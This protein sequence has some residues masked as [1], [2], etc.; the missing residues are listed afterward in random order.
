[1]P[2]EEA[3]DV[4]EESESDVVSDGAAT[5]DG[6]VPAE[7]E[8]K[9]YWIGQFTGSYQTPSTERS[10]RMWPLYRLL[11]YKPRGSSNKTHLNCGVTAT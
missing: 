11:L 7:L 8:S 10:Q 6:T 9:L 2:D 3:V 4:S 1:M 5:D